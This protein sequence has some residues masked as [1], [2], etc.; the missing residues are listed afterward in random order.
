[1]ARRDTHVRHRKPFAGLRVEA[2]EG[3]DLMSASPLPVLLVVADQQDFYYRE[4][5]ET[6]TAIE[7]Q[8]V[9]V[10]VG[11]TTTNPSTPHWGTGQPLGESGTIVPDVALA[12]V[13]AG[14]YSAIAFV[15]GWGASMYQYAY[16]DPNG[17]GV[18]DNFYS[19]PLYNAD[20]DLGDGQIA[21]EKVV[22]NQLIN[23]FLGDDKP[24]AG[25]CHGVTVLA[26]A[27]VDGASPLAG[28][29]V[30]VPHLEGTPDQF[31]NGQWRNGGYFN[32]QRDQVI[33][34][35]GLPTA[36]S[37]AHGKAGTADDVILDGQI[38]T[39]E[40][41]DSS[42]LFG[43][44]IAE[45]VL[46]D[47][48][49]ENRPPAAQ[50]DAWVLPENSPAGT[51]VGTVAATDPDAGQSLTFSIVGGNASGA[52]A[53]DP[54]TGQVT[55]AD[56]TA[57]NF[58]T[59]PVFN[60]TVE[61][62]DNAPDS[63]STVAA[64]TINLED[65]AESPVAPVGGNLV[66][67]GTSAADTVYLWNSGAD[68][69]SVW[70]NG[71]SYGP[72]ALPGG[73]VIVHGD[74]GND[75]IFASDLSTPATIYGGAGHD[76]IVGGSGADNLDGGDGVDRL[77]AGLGDDLLRGGD[78]DDYLYGREGNDILIGGAG[79]DALDGFD[80]RDIL[81]GGTG[82][83][84]LRGGNGDDILIGGSTGYDDDDEALGVL[85]GL[86]LAAGD[87]DERIATLSQLVGLGLRPGDTVLDDGV[88]DALVGDAGGDWLLSGWAD[89]IYLLDTDDRET[90][91]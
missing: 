18:T 28:K 49:A 81:I 17:D 12:D 3:R 74:A 78:G 51:V 44:T 77:W 56:A 36:Y 19:N 84:V 25:L 76:L 15:G 72:F 70:L 27:R 69:V 13:D 55:V 43:V 47:V 85:R 37:G 66:V 29:H 59:S 45:R 31:Y 24:V 79:N 8:G 22:V 61:V 23:E 82:A 1:M 10:V 89:G 83:D 57:L 6:R 58:E 52:F 65:V 48:P 73:R 87:I 14:D 80:G 50:D 21:P 60:L 86:W 64:V 5:S 32:G 62:S 20:P 26:W 68:Q 53:I 67:T 46:A 54:V 41:P 34:N 38:I 90:S 9:A 2:L 35:G 71:T 30:A 88:G 75:Q 42:T 33:D 40:N 63:L 39:G 7:T 11:A 16:N 91:V 4:Y